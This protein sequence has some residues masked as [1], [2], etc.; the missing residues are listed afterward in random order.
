[1]TTKQYSGLLA[2]ICV[3]ASPFVANQWLRFAK[4]QH[5]YQEQLKAEQPTITEEDIKAAAAD[6]WQN[7][8]VNKQWQSFAKAVDDLQK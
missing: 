2:L 1:M 4:A 3:I 5:A 6:A 8:P 7:L